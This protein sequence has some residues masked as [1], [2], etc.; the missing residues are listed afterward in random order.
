MKYD[1]F[2]GASTGYRKIEYNWRDVILYALG[3]G[4]NEEELDFVYEKN[5]KII[6][7]FG[8]IP[9][10][11]TIKNEPQRPLPYPASEILADYL[12]KETGKN[13]NGL[14]MSLD[15]RYYRPMDAVKGTLL[16]EDK[17]EHIY[18]W[19]SKGIV[20]TTKMPV[21]D[22]AG[23]LI[24]E[25]ISTSGYFAGGEFGGPSM[26]KNNTIIPNCVPDVIVK[27]AFSRTQ[28]LLYR[29]SGDTNL[30]H[31]D[32]ETAK[33]YGQPKPFMQ[34]L[35]SYGY[36]C[37][38]AIKTLIP[39]EPER[40]KRMFAQMRSIVLPG[41][42]IELHMWKMAEGRAVFRLVNSENG[43]VILDKGEFEWDE[44]VKK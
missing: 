28:N 16:Y 3:I 34:G 33:S 26:P 25:N 19:G 1:S 7:T 23:R 20:I 41:T 2:I 32:P 8:T 15:F 29:L 24:C 9:C 11:N 17:I 27:D 30:G 43:S 5:L 4:A 10:F 12:R 38:M 14:H 36:A 31:V 40:M 35:C 18:D 39:N 42:Q 13:V 21:Y 22:E 37:R 44:C 6:P